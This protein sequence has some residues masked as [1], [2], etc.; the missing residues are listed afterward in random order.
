MVRVKLKIKGIRELLRSNPVQSEIA[1]RAKSM[2]KAAGP[3]IEAVVKPHKYT[4][5]AFVQT[6]DDVGR[7]RQAEEAVLQ[8]ALGLPAN[9]VAQA[10]TSNPNGKIQYTTA[11]GKKV[12]ATPAQ[13]MHWTRALG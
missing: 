3:G 12:W 13:V 4:A 5:R 11:S 8:R 6:V 1:R 7:I 2:A 10:P 9:Y